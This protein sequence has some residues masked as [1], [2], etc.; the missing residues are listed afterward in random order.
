MKSLRCSFCNRDQNEVRALIAGQS[1]F[2]CDECVEVC[3]EIVLAS[4]T[5]HQRR[6]SAST[7]AWLQWGR[8]MTKCRACARI[9]P[10]E[11]PSTNQP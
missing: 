8:Q 10:S 3:Q 4:T 2:I 1:G 5:S 6:T 9:W 7:I 11:E